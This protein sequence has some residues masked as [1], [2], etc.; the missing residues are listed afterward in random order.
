MVDLQAALLAAV[1]VDDTGRGRNA[2]TDGDWL[3]TGLFES[4][5]P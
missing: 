1:V 4:R 3:H 5:V 2:K